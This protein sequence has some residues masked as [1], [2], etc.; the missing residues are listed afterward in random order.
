MEKSLP[1]SFCA[2]GPLGET[3]SSEQVLSLVKQLPL[4][5]QEGILHFLLLQPWASW[6]NLTYDAP[7]KARLAATKR[8]Q[9]WDAMT[10]DEREAFIDDLV[11]EA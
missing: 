9:N 7:E 10:E 4:E 5:Q 11:H 6:L 3:K 2:S 8:G 1:T